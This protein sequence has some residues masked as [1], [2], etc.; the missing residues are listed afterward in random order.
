VTSST[1]QKAA[2][3][4]QCAAVGAGILRSGRD[5]EICGDFKAALQRPP[6]GL[7]AAG[8]LINIKDGVRDYVPNYAMSENLTSANEVICPVCG[9]PMI[10]LHTIRRAFADNLNVFKCKPCGFSTTERRELDNPTVVA[11]G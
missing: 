9:L 8:P 4:R 2:P 3:P 7:R 11:E 6:I 5:Q 1:Y 10:L